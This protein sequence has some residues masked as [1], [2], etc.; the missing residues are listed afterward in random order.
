[1]VAGFAVE[2]PALPRPGADFASAAEGYTS[3]AEWVPMKVGF[4]MFSAP[5]FERLCDSSPRP[6]RLTSRHATMRIPLGE[7]FDLSRLRVVAVDRGGRPLPPAP[8][9]IEVEQT[10]PSLFDLRSETISQGRLMPVQ[11]GRTRIRVRSLCDDL[12]AEVILEVASALLFPGD[13][14]FEAET[15]DSVV[16]AR[17]LMEQVGTEL[18]ASLLIDNHVL[19]GTVSAKE[20]QFEA[21]LSHSDGS[22]PGHS[23]V[24]H[25]RG[26]LDGGRILGRYECADGS[27]QGEWKATRTQF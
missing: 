13:W 25:L 21:K 23:E 24:L 11:T 6:S 27:E 3:A 5:D 10:H 9:A 17:L 16:R 2:L 26:R 19:E 7:W 22:G 14:T 15:Q 20:S 12:S 4:R 8:V 1:M 18:L